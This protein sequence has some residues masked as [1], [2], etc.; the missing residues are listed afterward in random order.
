MY[1]HSL[2]ECPQRQ[3]EGYLE[4]IRKD[5][6]YN[7]KCCLMRNPEFREISETSRMSFRLKANFEFS[8]RQVKKV[9]VAKGKTGSQK[10]G[11][12]FFD[13]TYVV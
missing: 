9:E 12:P 10:T 6:A 5:P 11:I 3:G 2:R 4:K 13:T 8:S 1:P 7:A